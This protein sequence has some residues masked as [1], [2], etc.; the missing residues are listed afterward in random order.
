MK[1]LY[2]I[3]AQPAITFYTWQIEVML[4]NFLAN[5]IPPDKIHLL[6]AIER[7]GVPPEWKKLEEKYK[8]VGFYYY[9]DTRPPN[10]YI[11]S[12]KLN[13][14]KQHFYHH[15]ELSNH[16]IFFHD[17][18]VVFTR[19]VDWSPWVQDDMWYLSD[20]VSYIGEQ[21]IKSKGFG[22]YERMCE[23]IG[24]DQ[25]VPQR[26]QLHS[27]GAQY[28]LKNVSSILWDKAEEDSITLYNFFCQHLEEHPQTSD[29]HPI[30]KWTAEMWAT[31]WNAWY[32]GH[33]T[34]VIPEMD[35]IWPHHDLGEW[36]KHTIFHN[37][38][39]S[40][41]EK[42]KQFFKGEFIHRLPYGIPDVYDQTLTS[43]KYYE[44]IQ[45]TG[46]TTCLIP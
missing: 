36:E 20:T 44:M 9:Y 19:P 21:Y 39:V 10:G 46:Q 29:Y 27:G 25:T 18:D 37:S 5:G 35:F 12:I 26:N 16:A 22:I 2:Y 43:Y 24:L 40:G 8:E 6:L 15:P 41:H 42:R 1:Q 17:C 34:R 11:P 30:Q 28:L 7:H 32:F 45:K 13:L 14:M 3:C 31:L 23:M 38:G 4:E 33:E